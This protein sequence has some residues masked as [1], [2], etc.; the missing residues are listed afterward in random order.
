MEEEMLLLHLLDG[1]DRRKRATRLAV[2]LKKRKHYQ[3]A[4]YDLLCP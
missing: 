1:I 4:S 2:L 3:V